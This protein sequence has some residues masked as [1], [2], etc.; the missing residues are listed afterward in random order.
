[1]LEINISALSK[2]KEPKYLE[3]SEELLLYINKLDQKNLPAL[4]SLDHISETLNLNSRT[5]ISMCFSQEDFYRTFYIPKRSGGVRRIDAPLPAMYLAQKFI[6]DRI[7]KNLNYC[8]ESSTAY[9]LNCSIKEHVK[10]HINQ[11][12]LLKIDLKNFFPSIGFDRVYKLLVEIGY[13]TEVS[14][15][16]ANLLTLHGALPQ[17][18]PSSPLLSN[19]IAFDLDKLLTKY[20]DYRKLTYTR[21]ADDLVISGNTIELSVQADIE[22]IIESQGFKIN[23]KKTKLYDPQNTIRH[24]TGLVINKDSIRIPKNTRR[25]IRQLSFYVEKFLFSD[26]GLEPNSTKNEVDFF[27]PDPIVIERLVGYLNF[28]IWIEPDSTFAKSTL[29]K[30][31]IIRIKLSEY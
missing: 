25:R 31:N 14:S 6:L 4:L 18:A 5:L 2:L 17:G 13:K 10:K 8:R 15:L 12:Y 30:I 28:W 27:F 19:V 1:L 29:E 26:I 7:V 24:L 16:L 22:K 9:S 20:C 3:H 23:R 11:E 21:Y